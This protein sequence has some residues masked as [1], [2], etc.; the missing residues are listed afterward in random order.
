MPYLRSMSWFSMKLSTPN[1]SRM[2]ANPNTSA[3]TRIHLAKT[4]RARLLSRC[5]RFS[6]AVGAVASVAA[7]AGRLRLV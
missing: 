3:W 4:W 5:Q 7:G 6:A 1:K 2:S